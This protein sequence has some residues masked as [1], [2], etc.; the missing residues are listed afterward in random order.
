MVFTGGCLKEMDLFRL[1]FRRSCK[2][3]VGAEMVLQ[4]I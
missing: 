1:R 4:A 2:V 3:N